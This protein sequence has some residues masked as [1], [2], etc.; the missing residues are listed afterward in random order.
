[1][2]GGRLIEVVGALF[3]VSVCTS[4]QYTQTSVEV[5]RGAGPTPEQLARVEKTMR[6]LDKLSGKKPEKR[7][8]GFPVG[9]RISPPAYAA[10][11]P[12]MVRRG[13]DHPL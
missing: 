2:S 7:A 4:P 11:L 3:D 12:G 1:M 6:A 13:C 9:R 5:G 10:K 8:A